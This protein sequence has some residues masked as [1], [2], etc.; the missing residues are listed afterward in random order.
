MA[1]RKSA[2][3]KAAKKAGRKGGNPFAKGGRFYK[4][5]N[6]PEGMDDTKKKKGGNPFAKGG[7]KAKVRGK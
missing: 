1:T 4:G 5:E 6:G 2:T 7:L 3:K